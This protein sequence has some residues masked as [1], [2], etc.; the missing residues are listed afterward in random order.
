MMQMYDEKDRAEADR[1]VGELETIE[2][3]GASS[4]EEKEEKIP[5]YKDQRIVGK[6]VVLII[7]AFLICK[8]IVEL[9]TKS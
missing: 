2:E 4:P 9:L 7:A 5:W 1:D 3:T 8:G 6:I